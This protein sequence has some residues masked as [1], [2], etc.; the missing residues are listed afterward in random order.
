[1]MEEHHGRRHQSLSSPL[2]HPPRPYA[3][4]NSGRGH[5]D[6]DGCSCSA[7]PETPPPLPSHLSPPTSPPAPAGSTAEARGHEEPQKRAFFWGGRLKQSWL[8]SSQNSLSCASFISRRSLH[9]LAGAHPAPR[10]HYPGQ[11]GGER[12]RISGAHQA[13]W[14]M[15]QKK[16][17]EHSERGGDMQE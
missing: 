4:L 14:F 13:V 6:D 7:G 8:L 17:K 9:Y 15:K 11:T 2:P 16:K 3:R 5:S 12:R 10:N 1:M